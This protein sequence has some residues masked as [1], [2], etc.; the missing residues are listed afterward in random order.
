MDVV[1]PPELSD[2]EK[3]RGKPLPSLNH[4]YVQGRLI[5]AFAASPEFSVIPE[6]TL[7]FPDQ[8]TLTP[9]LAVYRRRSPDWLNDGYPVRVMPRS[10]VEILSPS[11]GFKDIVEKLQVYFAHGVESA[12]VIQPYSLS[13]TIYLPGRSRPL[14]FAQ[15]DALDPATGLSARVEDIF[16]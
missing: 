7:G 11:Q 10:I 1:E 3:E 8:T 4:A 9:D 15:G 16:A 2:Y 6:P 5:V 13:L 14:I 12:W